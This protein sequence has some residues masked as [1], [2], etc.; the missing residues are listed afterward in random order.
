MRHAHITRFPVLDQTE[1]SWP[2]C[3]QRESNWRPQLGN[4][5]V[6]ISQPGESK[7]SPVKHRF[8]V[9]GSTRR[10]ALFLVRCCTKQPKIGNCT[11]L[12]DDGPGQMSVSTGTPFV[13]NDRVIRDVPALNS[14]RSKPPSRAGS[15]RPKNLNRLQ[16]GNRGGHAEPRR[17]GGRPILDH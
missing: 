14:S 10:C 17:R 9:L 6:A 13:S 11:L 4:P 8:G 2:L 1:P 15:V 16:G 12:R 7:K 5:P 3:E